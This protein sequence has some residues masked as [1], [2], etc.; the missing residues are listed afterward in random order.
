MSTVKLDHIPLLENAQNFDEWKRFISHVLCDEGYWGH[1]EGTN[2]PFNRYPKSNCPAACTTA[3]TATKIDTY[4][5]WW[6]KDG[7]ACG[8]ILC[9]VSPVTY[10]CLGTGVDMTAQT[11][12]Q[13][14][15]DMYV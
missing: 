14:L 13:Q 12:W 9:H 4:Q 15:H 11:I 3:S 7:K 6:R 8:L 10:S 5:E 2:N 1:V